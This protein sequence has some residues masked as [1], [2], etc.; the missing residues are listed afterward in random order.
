[1]NTYKSEPSVSVFS[2]DM[3]RAG[4]EASRLWTGRQQTVIKAAADAPSV[5]VRAR[6]RWQERRWA[7]SLAGAVVLW[8]MLGSG[9]SLPSQPHQSGNGTISFENIVER[10]GVN[11]VLDNSRTPEKHQIETMMGGVAVLDYDNDGWLDLFFANGAHLPDFDKSEPRFYNRLYRNLGNGT[12]ADVTE[13]AGLRGSGY[14][15]G[16]AVGDYDNDGFVDLY[17]TGVNRN[18]LFHNNGDGTFT[19]VTVKAG[20][21]GIHPQYGKT[22]AVS[23]GWFDYDN[24]GWL[25]LFVV[26]YLNWSIANAPPCAVKGVR[27]YCSPNSFEGQPNMLYRNQ[28]DGTFVDVS[29]RS[30]IGRQV[31]KGMGVAFA[32]YNGDGL[33]DVFVANDTFRNFLFRNEGQGKFTEVGIL[34]GVAFNENGRSIAGMG[35]DFRDVDN[36]GRPDLFVTAMI[37]DTFPLFRGLGG[38]QFADVTTSAGLAL[39]TINLTA[40]GNGIFDFDNDGLKDLFA[41]TGAILDNAMEIDRLPYELP[42]LLLRNQGRCTFADVSRQAGKSFSQPRAHRGAAFGDFTGD[43]RIDIVTTNLNASPELL[44]NRTQNANHWLMVKLTGTRSNRD[45][46]GAQLKLTTARGVQYNQ[47][48]T[49]VGYSSSSDRRIHFGLGPERLVEKLEITW[50]SGTRQT[51]T[52]LKADQVV[53]VREP[54]GGR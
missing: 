2:T 54:A 17:V 5:A 6:A 13:R 25:D 43:G 8:V 14:A 3:P 4:G 41:A 42:N 19:D 48:T 53:S 21:A 27:A 34:A 1:M 46:L 29:E 32:D 16:V 38:G 11:F 52:Q 12:F 28:G 36:D 37:G 47:A 40:W 7:L 24:D 18:Q 33:M 10:S 9:L 49:S 44:V 22:Y 31:G 35:A 45:G 39:P 26:N 15:M 20:V 23:A 51:L 50:P 30:Q